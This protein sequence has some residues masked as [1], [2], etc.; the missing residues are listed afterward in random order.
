[1]V[2]LLHPG[3]KKKCAKDYLEAST[4]I[5]A[6]AFNMLAMHRGPILQAR[7]MFHHSCGP[8]PLCGL[9]PL[10]RINFS[11][12]QTKTALAGKRYFPPINHHNGSK[13]RWRTH[14]WITATKHLLNSFIIARK[15]LFKRVPMISKD[16]F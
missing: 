11:T 12:E 2:L 16:L 5:V 3:M 13:H 14:F 7:W 4:W 15:C 9:C 10:I 1:M 8:L 6:L